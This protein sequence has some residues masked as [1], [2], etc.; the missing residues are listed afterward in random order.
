MITTFK[1]EKIDEF[2]NTFGYLQPELDV[3]LDDVGGSQMKDIKNFLSSSFD[4][5]HALVMS[6]IPRE[7][8]LLEHPELDNIYKRGR[9]HGFNAAIAEITSNLTKE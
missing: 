4:A 5:Y 8:K 1:K 6:K 3:L 9:R 2:Y 7:K